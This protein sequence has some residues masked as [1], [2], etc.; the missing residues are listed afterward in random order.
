MNDDVRQFVLEKCLAQLA[1]TVQY[2]SALVA[3]LAAGV[4]T[5]FAGLRSLLKLSPEKNIGSAKFG[6]MVYLMAA[7]LDPNYG[8]VW[9]DSDHPGDDTV[10]KHTVTN[11][12]VFEAARLI[13]HCTENQGPNIVI[14]ARDTDVLVLLLA[15]FHKIPSDKVWLK[16]GT[17]ANR[18][19]T[20]C[21]KKG[22][23]MLSIVTLKR[24]IPDTTGHQTAIQFPTSPNIC[25]YTT[26][27]KPN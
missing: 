17:A 24:I 14:A 6:H 1:G 19:Y 21:L 13:L 18:K 2:H 10:K 27:G 16:A 5:R 25:F 15:H 9:L 4:K 26:W 12:V 7:A 20:L 22:T 8:F 23:P 11:A 3:N